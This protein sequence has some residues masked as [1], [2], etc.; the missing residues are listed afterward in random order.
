MRLLRN[1]VRRLESVLLAV[2]VVAM[3]SCAG[4]GREEP[5]PGGLTFTI[6]PSTVDQGGS[7]TLR[8]GPTQ[9]GSCSPDSVTDLGDGDII[10]IKYLNGFDRVVMIYNRN[11]HKVADITKNILKDGKYTN[12][13]DQLESAVLVPDKLKAEKNVLEIDGDIMNPIINKIEIEISIE[14]VKGYAR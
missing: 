14:A 8:D 3:S 1:K 7:V 6:Y 9:L 12:P 2:T 11:T 4:G 5:A 10:F 13:K